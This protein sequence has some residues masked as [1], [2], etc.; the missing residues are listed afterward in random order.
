MGIMKNYFKDYSIEGNEL[1]KSCSQLN[2]VISNRQEKFMTTAEYQEA[3]EEVMATLKK[4]ESLLPGEHKTLGA[5]EDSIFHTERACYS[6]AYRDG[7][8]DLMTALTF[9]E[10][11]LTKVEYCDFSNKSL[12]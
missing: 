12:E 8:S 4:I 6:A 5:P 2:E 7:V 9:N 10:I 3:K 11:G 1:V